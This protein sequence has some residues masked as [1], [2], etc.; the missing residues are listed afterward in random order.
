VKSEATIKVFASIINLNGNKSAH[1]SGVNVDVQT[2]TKS[3]TPIT[4][5]DG[6][7]Y[8]TDGQLTEGSLAL[9]WIDDTQNGTCLNCGN[10]E[11]I[12]P[13]AIPDEWTDSKNLAVVIAVLANDEDGLGNLLAGGWV[14]PATLSPT[15][16]KGG[17]LTLNPDGTV[18]YEP[19]ADW[20][21]D[22]NGEF[23]D[24]FEYYVVDSDGD[25]SADPALVTIVLIN[26]APVANDDFYSVGHNM[27][28][29]VDETS[30]TIHG[31]I[32]A[33]ADTDPDN[34]ISGAVFQDDLD[35]TS[36][37]DGSYGT[38]S[39]NEET[40]AFTYTPD[41]TLMRAN[42]GLADD[43]FSYTISDGF[44]GTDTAVVTIDLTNVGPDAVADSYTNIH[45]LVLDVD[46]A[47]G[48][49]SGL[50]ADSDADNTIGA[51]FLDDLDVTSYTDGSYG[52]VSFNEETGAFTYTPDETLM[53]ANPTLADDTFSYTISDGFGGTDTA[54]VTIDLTNVGPDAVADSY[55]NSHNL[56]LD[57]DG[58]AGVIS[59][60]GA[61][62]DAD[63][64][65]GA[66]FLDDL[67]V[68]SYTQP[69]YG[70]VSF[71]QETGA[72]TYTPD[73]TLMRANPGLA[74]DTFSY[75]I[76]DGF[77]GT[78]SATVTI[79]LTNQVPVAQPDGYD[80]SINTVLDLT[81]PGAPAD[82]IDGVLPSYHDYDPD[83]DSIESYLVGSGSTTYG[84]SVTLYT[85]GTLVYNPPTNWDGT[86]S[87]MYYVNDG[88]SSSDPVWVTIEVID[89]T[90]AFI[91]PEEVSST[92]TP[93]SVDLGDIGQIEG[94]SMENLLWLAEELGLC[95]G[96]EQGE[97]EG[98]C[99]EITQ[100]YLAGAFL[101]STDLR[102][103]RAAM[104]LR[105]LVEV[106]QD[107]DG[108]RTGALT[109]VVGE[110]VQGPVP[111]SEEQMA[112]IAETFAQ[113]S[114]DGTHY[115]SAG[116]WL[117]ALAEYVGI[118]NTEIGWQVDESVAFVMGKYCAGITEAGDVS[119]TAYVQMY[120]EGLGV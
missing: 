11:R 101:Q 82:V 4:D 19:P 51:V 33:Y 68:A 53:R 113:H 8:D 69:S 93:S 38:V 44:G 40:G 9:V 83:G 39:F 119:T 87:F 48:V 14:D 73:E 100:A 13:I 6:A 31:L 41:E 96:D 102:P 91:A 75:T 86:D 67:D 118:L 10:E 81:Q 76:S 80:G 65:I 95:D 107:V 12:L 109:R 99:Q 115:A 72:F 55:T 29:S 7:V 98:R 42:P 45:N 1:A 112:S 60:L 111:P 106:L 74:D 17:T 85:D 97:D 36:Y 3:T 89:D 108:A 46:G 116:Q 110:F 64:T 57:V 22:E 16:N 58:A 92:T 63:N 26:Q 105:T 47:A 84:G 50:G 61:D 35:V 30:G 21:F 37:T 5:E 20:V 71:D 52:T 90:P 18:Q 2:S 104:Q 114:N 78:D 32:P 79:H 54:T 27:A 103:H 56:V 24:Y 117:D 34:E 25:V 28:L 94:M 77:G 70:T 120:L 23:T 49:I 66:V 62:S 43:T 88:F 15:S 59:G